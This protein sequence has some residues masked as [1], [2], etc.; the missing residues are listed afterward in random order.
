[1]FAH[2]HKAII[3]MLCGSS[4]CIGRHRVE[5]VVAFD[6]ETLGDSRKHPWSIAADMGRHDASINRIIRIYSRRV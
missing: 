5:A 4:A 2:I 1:M 3:N 6:R